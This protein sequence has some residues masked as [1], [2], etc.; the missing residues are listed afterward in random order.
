MA[1]ARRGWIREWAFTVHHMMVD[2][3]DLRELKTA[4][5]HSASSRTSGKLFSALSK[6]CFTRSRHAYLLPFFEPH[7][8][9]KPSYDL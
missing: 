3:R 1:D 2:D 6:S 9:M 8:I 7:I 4:K 5:K